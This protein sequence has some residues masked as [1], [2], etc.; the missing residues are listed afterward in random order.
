[1]SASERSPLLSADGTNNASDR[2]SEDGE[3]VESTPLLS[4]SNATPRYDG[5]Q[6]EP[7]DADAASISPS[8]GDAASIKSTKSK[9]LRWPSIIAM[10]V[11]ATFTLTVMVLAFFVPAAVEEYAKEALVLEP[12]NLSLD[13]IT[14]NGIRARI[15][16]NFRLDAQRVKNE[17]VRRIGRAAT[18][19]VRELGTEETKFQVFLP[20]Y[21]DI[22]LGTAGVPPLS[23]GIVDGHNTA[24]DFVADLVPGDAEGIRT[25]VNDWL[26]GRLDVLRLRGKADI[27]LK[28]GFLSL[29]THSISETLE[30]EANKMVPQLPAYNIT[31]MNVREEPIP[32]HSEMAMAAEVSITAFNKHPVSV[33][34]PQLG[35]EVFVPGCSPYDPH[36]L[37][38][39]ATTGIVLVRP[40]SDVVVAAHGL[41][42]E[43]PELLTRTC[44]GS[45]SSPLDLFFRKYIAGKD[46]TVFVR[47]QKT[48]L[49]GT[50]TWVTEILS[51]IT[52][53]V[54][55][56][57]RSFDNLIRS[58][59]L[60]DVHFTL[61][62]PFA[63]PGDPDADPKVSGTIL[64]L[65]GLPAEMNFSINVTK[66][67]ANADV[68]YHS[69]KLG[70]L[71][72]MEWQKANST[73]IP[74][75]EDQESG[76]E[77]QS[78]IEDAP[79]N[80]TDGDVLAAIVQALLFGNE[81][82]ILGINALV[83]V[84]VQTIL[85][86]LVIKEVPAQGKVPLKRLS[87]LR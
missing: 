10:I 49:P 15:Q 78:R 40:H 79:L 77:I 44:P 19:L 71:N 35:F 65:A 57:G 55:F 37:V 72:L 14:T 18:W 69:K 26:E 80:V 31:K 67:R 54:P 1:M 43:L 36:I 48:P 86:Q 29:G 21:D 53:P 6:D 38:A 42:R 47:G 22:L 75:G 41:V 46:A 4:S 8:N 23:V 13:S 58:F 85:G 68:F 84:K 52:V 81:E 3:S 66:V 70:E 17:H 62:D 50:P 28:S 16:A 12:T 73:Q 30:I 82:I 9:S 64:V 2:R 20:E 5:E 59:S 83:D 7:H 76:L 33:D 39:V 87:S 27:Q 24:I 51:S 32:G 56:P 45:D 11:L 34:V 61:P 63:E 74:A 25:I 60:T